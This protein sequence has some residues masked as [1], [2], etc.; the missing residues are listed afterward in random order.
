[1]IPLNFRSIGGAH[2]NPG[3]FRACL[4]KLRI[5]TGEVLVPH[6]DYADFIATKMPTLAD[7]EQFAAEIGIA[8][9]I[10]VGCLQRDELLPRRT[11]NR[12]KVDYE[13]MM[14]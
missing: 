6:N 11:G 8:P 10:V 14:D 5:F 2:N 9:G 1:M 3:Q 13:W 4:F 12:L 7:I